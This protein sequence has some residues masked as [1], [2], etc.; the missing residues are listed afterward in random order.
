MTIATFAHRSKQVFENNLPAILTGTAIAGT[1]VTAVFAG[2]AGFRAGYK[3]AT[4]EAPGGVPEETQNDRYKRLAMETWKLYLPSAISGVGTIGALAYA[5]RLH[6]NRTAAIAAAYNIT[7][8][9]FSEYKSK[10]TDV[11]GEK[12][13]QTSV[14]DAIAKDR[15][16]AHGERGSVV[17][18]PEGDILCYDQFTDR[19]FNS[20]REAI[21]KAMNDTNYEIQNN[22]YVSL[23]EFYARL[24]LPP[25]VYGDE[26]GWASDEKLDLNFTSTITPNEK[27]ALVINFHAKPRPIR[28]VHG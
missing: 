24:G 7:N 2:R 1:V 17:V 14:Q 15:I 25:V 8:S 19:Y 6:T 9:A 11:L 12:K 28:G 5:N 18:V 4:E 22:L 20:S 23:N 3:V 26:I 27:T 13:E 10:V 21:K 16:A